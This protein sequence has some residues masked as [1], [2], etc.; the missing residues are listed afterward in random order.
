MGRAYNTS[1]AA[2]VTC[3]QLAISNITQFVATAIGLAFM[4]TMWS[5]WLAEGL[6]E[7]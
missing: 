2:D 4:E 5:R 7:I 6:A 3:L 1:R